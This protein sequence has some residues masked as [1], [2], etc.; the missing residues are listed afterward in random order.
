MRIIGAFEY[1]VKCACQT[2]YAFSSEEL[3]LNR[4]RL[5]VCHKCGLPQVLESNTILRYSE[6]TIEDAT[7]GTLL[8]NKE[9]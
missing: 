1:I 6:H 9:Q 5:F 8:E 4:G 7:I 3:L 2:R